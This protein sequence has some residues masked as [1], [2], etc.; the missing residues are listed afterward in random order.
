MKMNVRALSLS[1]IATTLLGAAFVASLLTACS[2]DLSKGDKPNIELFLGIEGTISDAVYPL[3][4]IIPGSG[5]RD[6]VSVDI[7]N[8]GD[9]PLTLT[10]VE[11][12]PTNE[13]GT[14]GNQWVT[15]DWGGFDPALGFPHTI[16]PNDF[17]TNL[18]I[19][20]VYQ[21]GDCSDGA[22]CG[23][24]NAVTV[25]F[26]SDDDDTPVLLRVFSP[27]S[28][29]PLPTVQP[30]KDTYFNA[31][32]IQPETKTFQITNEGTC[33]TTVE[34]VSFG[35]PT[36]KFTIERDWPNGTTLLSANEAGYAPLIFKVKY[37][38]TD[39]NCADKTSVLVKTSD[40][41]TA[42]PV[43]LS[44]E[45]EEGGFEVSH[46][47]GA[48]PSKLDFTAVQPGSEPV[49]CIVNVNNLGP[50]VMK[51]QGV[52]LEGDL[53][54][55]HYT[56][57]GQFP[58]ETTVL[59]PLCTGP[60]GQAKTFALNA[61]KSVD[62][63]ITY[64]PSINGLN[65]ELAIN[66]N[67]PDNG[68]I[69]LPAFGGSPK[70]CFEY[71]PGDAS[72]PLPVQFLGTKGAATG[73]EF[74]IYNCGNA[75]LTIDAFRFEDAFGL[76]NESQYFSLTSANPPPLT[77][78]AGALEVFDID[79]LVED[80]EIEPDSVMF[81][82]YQDSTGTAI[83]GF[84][85]NLKGK[86]DAGGTAP[87]AVITSAGAA[88]VGQPHQMTGIDSVAGSATVYDKGYIW[89]MVDKPAGSNAIVNGPAGSIAVTWLPDVPG[90]YT[91]GLIVHDAPADAKD[92]L[93]SNMATIDIVVGE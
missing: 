12:L 74:V 6:I 5:Q 16:G 26:T 45:C 54:G 46:N 24:N 37:Q 4:P 80:N 56:V 79:M 60:E 67:N 20:I 57:K 85:V 25:R 65:G 76:G 42:L 21:P 52:C 91:F 13:D 49:E 41:D 39:G 18:K 35:S 44:S 32:P 30:P 72:S 82:D 15:I 89:M 2:S 40:K 9:A 43:Q 81:I 58:G 78:A 84:G 34:D 36:S 61:N 14:P 77:I 93:F 86:V 10:L 8:T 68:T 71:A 70:S 75:E 83:T 92:T 29:L 53:E 17:T 90:T 55:T 31:S 51:I 63:K 19:N 11:I 62:I 59:E 38:P 22:A 66:Y 87:T 50:S 64:K 33:K 7:R 27:P 69:R 73:R 47:C 3:A 28:C 23:Y 88:V 1:G 48:D